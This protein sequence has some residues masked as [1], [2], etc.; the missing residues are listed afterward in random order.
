MENSQNITTDIVDAVRRAHSYLVDLFQGVRDSQVDV[1][2]MDAGPDSDIFLWV[3]DAGL[4]PTSRPV[5]CMADIHVY[6]Q[7]GSPQ[8]TIEFQLYA[9]GSGSDFTVDA[10]FER[11]SGAIVIH[12]IHVL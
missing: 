1:S 8:C 3:K 2:V 11:E 7:E 10:K 9:D 5:D 4:T 12:D 6:G